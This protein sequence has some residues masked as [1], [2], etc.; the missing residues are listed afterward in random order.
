LAATN[1]PGPVLI[2][3]QVGEMASPWPIIHEF[4]PSPVAPPPNPLGPGRAD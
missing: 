4:V 2:E 1:E 3:V